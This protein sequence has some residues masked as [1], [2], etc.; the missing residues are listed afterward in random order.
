MFDGE[1][2]VDASYFGGLSKGQRG[3]GT[4]GKTPVGIWA[5]KA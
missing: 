1:V 3:R 5:L 2:K 4:A